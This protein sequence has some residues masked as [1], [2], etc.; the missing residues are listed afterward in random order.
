MATSIRCQTSIR[1]G[2]VHLSTVLALMLAWTADAELPQNLGL[3]Y[4]R[5][6][7]AGCPSERAIRRS[8]GRCLASGAHS[9]QKPMTA[10][11]HVQ[12]TSS[13]LVTEVSVIDSVGQRTGV[14]RFRGQPQ[15]CRQLTQHAVLALCLALEQLSER[16]TV[17][18]ASNARPRGEIDTQDSRHRRP[19]HPYYQL[20]YPRTPIATVEPPSP[21]R[22]RSAVHTTALFGLG[23]L[24][25]LGPTLSLELGQPHWGLSISGTWSGRANRATI[26]GT[27][28]LT[29]SWL[30]RIRGDWW[31]MGAHSRVDIAVGLALSGGMLSASATALV[32]A[33]S[34]MEPIALFGPSVAIKIPLTETVAL[35]ARLSGLGRLIAP[36]LSIIDA[37]GATI[38]VFRPW[39]VSLFIE[40][41]IHFRLF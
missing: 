12:S 27:K 3:S 9:L 38:S 16:A 34:V 10:Q 41:G 30:L 5:D 29:E 32:N 39:P 19:P 18:D 37:A 13:Q 14:R 36:D 6:L 24:P 11:I 8:L 40:T 31:I 7:S 20:P 25:T 35:S 2:R 1:T 21:L 23:V 26:A 22:L 4:M 33:R 28:L 17:K 15:S